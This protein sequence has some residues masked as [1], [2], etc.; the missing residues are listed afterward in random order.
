MK[1]L[2]VI[3]MLAA[4][5]LL[6]RIA[7][8]KHVETKKDRDVQHEKPNTVP[9][10]M[11]KSRFVLHDGSQSVQTP[12]TILETENVTEKADIFAAK[13]EERK[14]AVIPTDELDEVFDENVN[15]EIMS[16]P[17]DEHGDGDE[18]EIDFGIEEAEEQNRASG[19]ERAFAEGF[20]YDELQTV[21]KAVNEQPETVSEKTVRTIVALEHTDMFDLLANGDEGKMNW[22]K[23]IIDRHVQSTMPET[24]NEEINTD[25]GDFELSDFLS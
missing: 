25:Y 7:F 22:I 1:F 16:I 10:V 8:P 23:T 5:Y 24:E 18:D 15:P 12:A 3:I 19:Q 17:L 9:D 21:A 6:Y 11:G 20:D 4:L 13:T 14:S 2:A